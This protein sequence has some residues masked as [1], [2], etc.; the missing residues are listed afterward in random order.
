MAEP[1]QLSIYGATIRFKQKIHSPPTPINCMQM[2]ANSFAEE[3]TEGMIIG[4]SEYTS[5]LKVTFVP[6]NP[7]EM[8]LIGVEFADPSKQNETQKRIVFNQDK[9]KM[10][11][12]VGAVDKGEI[13]SVKIINR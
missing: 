12:Q 11:L 7:E 4:V 3:V 8:H 2:K 6:D 10:F 5:N 9:S 1:L 13:E